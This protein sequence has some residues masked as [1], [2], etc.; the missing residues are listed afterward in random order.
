MLLA[1]M[2]SSALQTP[3]RDI[4]N[5]SLKLSFIQE[6]EESDSPGVRSGWE[7]GVEVASVKSS[8]DTGMKCRRAA[9][10]LVKELRSMLAVWAASLRVM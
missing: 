9:C 1:S 10:S 6:L 3:S 5:S 4:Q 7:I 2:L 8:H